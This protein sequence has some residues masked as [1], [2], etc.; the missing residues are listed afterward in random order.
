MM[1]V[2]LASALGLSA[3]EARAAAGP[4]VEEIEKAG[5][6][7]EHEAIA[8]EYA[9]EAARLR[10]EVAKHQQM[11]RSYKRKPSYRKQG[12]RKE[13]GM[14][15]HCE[16]LIEQYGKAAD[17]AEALARQHRQ[18][19]AEM[20]VEAGE[21]ESEAAQERALAEQYTKEAGRLRQQAA[22]HERMARAYEGRPLYR[23][24]GHGAGPAMV[25]HCK[26]L[27]AKLNA[28]AEQAEA[29]AKLH[30]EHAEKGK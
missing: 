11:L 10:G 24:K 12:Q 1:V 29:M 19:A 16:Q 15:E 23:Q 2:A 6:A 8:E 30:T 18:L 27:V 7:A 14:E 9:Q 28:A 17:D 5:T 3:G 25:Q 21:G 4:S 13:A 26:N 22:K 20:E